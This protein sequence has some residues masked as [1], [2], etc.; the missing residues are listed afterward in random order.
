M[1]GTTLDKYEVLQKV[2]E[3][4]MA[5]VY[6]GRHATLKRDVAIKV[7]HPHLS[8]S[9]RNRKRFA[10]EARAIEQLRHK[11]ILEIFDYSGLEASDCYIVTE[12]VDGQTLTSLL[13][14]RGRL[15]SEI[16]ALI[17]VHVARALSYAHQAGILHRD[18]KT[19]NVMVRVDG[20]VKLMDFGIARFLDESQV[21]MTGALVGSPAFMSPEQAKESPLDVRSDLFALGT[22][23]FYL[24]TGH[25]P[26]SGSNASLILKN[27]IEGNRPHVTELAP[28]MSA[29]LADVIERALSVEPSGRQSSAAEID[30][31]L[32]SCLTEAG[33]DPD[34]ER[35]QLRAYVDD[36][37]AYE[38]RLEAHLTEVLV[39]AGR[40]RLEHGDHLAA[41]RLFNRLLS[42]DEDN[43]EV[44]SLVQGLHVSVARPARDR[45]ARLLAGGALLLLGAALAGLWLLVARSEPRV[46]EAA[47]VAQIVAPVPKVAPPTPLPP[48]AFGPVPPN[49]PP[50][51]ALRAATTALAPAVSPS[52][53]PSAAI[54]PEPTPVGEAEPAPQEAPA[55]LI[56]NT[57]SYQADVYWREQKLGTTREQHMI[58]PGIYELSLRSGLFQTEVIKV[59][60]APG[61]KKV[62]PV[63]LR[64]LPSTISFPA[65]W[66]SACVVSANGADR[67][68]IGGMADRAL[69][70]DRPDRSVEVRLECPEQGT[71]T[72]T[73]TS[74]GPG[75]A[76]FP[77]PAPPAP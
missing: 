6:R 69:T 37:A 75:G 77:L 45:R 32:T 72:H 25:L 60:V 3:G 5:T 19:D 13:Q 48:T 59:S 71:A 65:G 35:W 63:T 55:T 12:F 53:P 47:P 29:S 49:E 61:E 27:V 16:V 38:A 46:T 10:R 62:V 54:A 31:A 64:V 51:A 73:W 42:M 11:N 34:D 66:A 8:S 68:N 23:L 52:P 14:Q 21:T 30:Q 22:V 28:T 50:Q 74:V 4:G 67:G 24:V 18:L 36:A 26:F 40:E 41:L 15:P 70:V 17:G 2:G 7:L 58:P 33:I 76:S 57:G 44:L 43:T 1:I 9:L 39:A 20:T 56:L